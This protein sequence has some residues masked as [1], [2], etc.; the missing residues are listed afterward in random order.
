M[1]SGGHFFLP[2]AIQLLSDFVQRLNR[3]SFMVSAMAIPSMLSLPF[4][5]ASPFRSADQRFISYYGHVENVGEAQALRDLHDDLFPVTLS[6]YAMLGDDTNYSQSRHKRLADYLYDD[7]GTVGDVGELTEQLRQPPGCFCRVTIWPIQD[8]ERF[9]KHWR[10]FA[11][12]TH[13]KHLR[14]SVVYV[15][16]EI[17]VESQRELILLKRQINR[18]LWER[19]GELRIACRKRRPLVQLVNRQIIHAMKKMIVV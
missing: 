13:G 2:K 18:N 12:Q 15:T 6:R 9:T 4:K 14:L 17:S 8:D 7:Y 16:S 19:R 5:T 3:R 1:F 11:T 10:L